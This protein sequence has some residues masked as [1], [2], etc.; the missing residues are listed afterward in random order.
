MQLYGASGRLDSDIAY[1]DWQSISAA[2]AAGSSAAAQGSYPRDIHIW[3][4]Q[5]DYKLEIRI[6][7]LTV[8]EDIS[9]DRFELT[10]PEGTDL[11][12]VGEE[13]SGKQP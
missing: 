13:Q 9:A 11:V 2:P 8:N 7:K 1:S 5:D 6:L 4:P 12:H 10:Q 3:R